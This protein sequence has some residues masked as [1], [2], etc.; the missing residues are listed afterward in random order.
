MGKIRFS[1]GILNEL[2]V[3]LH[4]EQ[5]EAKGT[6][7]ENDTTS[8]MEV[9]PVPQN[10][11]DISECDSTCSSQQ[12]MVVEKLTEGFTAEL[13]PQLQDLREKT[14]ELTYVL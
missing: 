4:M 14:K 5:G 7:T 10:V 11:G 6:L 9:Q 2:D 12:M 8:T 1:D 3:C 13:L